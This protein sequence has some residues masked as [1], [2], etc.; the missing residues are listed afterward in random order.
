MLLGLVGKRSCGKDTSYILIASM[1][2]NTHRL[3]IG[4]LIAMEYCRIHKL[5]F[6]TVRQNKQGFRTALQ[7]LGAFRRANDPNYWTKKLDVYVNE[8]KELFPHKP[9]IVITDIRM[10]TDA[11]YVKRVGGKLIRLRRPTNIDDNHISE[12]ETE[13]IDCDANISNDSNIYH[14]YDSLRHSIQLVFNGYYEL[15]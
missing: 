3:S 8:I 4:D 13:L 12:T 14:L 9:L 15:R 10:L 6:N 11:E 7:N 5:E 1:Y 2:E